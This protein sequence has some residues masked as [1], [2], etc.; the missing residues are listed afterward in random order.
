MP[1]DIYE[2]HKKV[3]SLINDGKTVLDIGGEL[4]HLSL[5][6]KP[7][8]ITVANL[9]TGDVIITKDKIP[10]K[11]KSF[12]VVCSIDVLEHIPKTK[13]EAFV[14]NLCLIANE[15]VIMSFPIGTQRHI[16][17][18]MKT[19]NWLKKREQ[20]VEYLKEHIL[21]GLPTMDE[22]NTIVEKKKL[23]VSFSGNIAV[24]NLLFRFYMFDP[25]IK[26][27]RRLIFLLK[28]VFNLFTNQI[29]YTILAN[30]KFGQNINRAYISIDI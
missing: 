23:A 1:Y 7:K 19:Y 3:G 10:F 8:K 25:R 30:K 14:K 21:Y 24:N 4:N 20:N 18:E 9:N 27:V 26:I 6:C 13:R 17:Y 16:A 28:S 29:L 5:F 15:K 12:D 2:R 22:I 11:N